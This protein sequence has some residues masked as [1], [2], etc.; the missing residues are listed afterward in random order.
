VL[1]GWVE[2]ER[3]GQ[4]G[5]KGGGREGKCKIRILILMKILED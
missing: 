1:L 5:K 4:E 3:G 2:E